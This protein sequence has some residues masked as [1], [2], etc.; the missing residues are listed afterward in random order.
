[1]SLTRFATPYESITNPDKTEAQ[2][3]FYIK[4]F[5]DKTNSTIIIEDAGI[6]MTKNEL[7]NNMDAIGKSGTKAFMETMADGCD[8]STLGQFGV[9]LYS[10]Y[11]VSDKVR[12]ICKHGDDDHYIWECGTGG[13]FTIQKDSELIH[14]DIKRG[15]KV[16]CHVTV[17]Q[18]DFLE[19]C[20][21]KELA[22]KHSE[23]IGFPIELY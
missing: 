22:K 16:I 10:A 9:G 2:P 17:D 19:E 4:V 21:L 3:N 1:M 20:R 6:G 23:I 15:A 18:S 12:V 11:L 13:S 8:I 5:L 7:I 14:G